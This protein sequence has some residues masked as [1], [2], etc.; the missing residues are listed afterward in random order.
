MASI[1]DCTLKSV[2]K[3]VDRR[4]T[5]AFLEGGVDTGFEIKR[6]Y[7]TYDVPSQSTR[8]GH[9]HRALR[10]MYLALSGS[11]DVLLDDGKRRRTVTLNRPDVGLSLVPGIWREIHNFSTNAV[12]LVL[13]SE[14]YDEADYIRRYSDFKAAVKAGTL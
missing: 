3:S 2:R 10:Q 13:A 11:F 12:L 7:Y 6:V 5:L 1:D 8:A 9:A 14:H 4:G